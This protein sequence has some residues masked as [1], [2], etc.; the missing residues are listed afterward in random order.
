MDCQTIEIDK[1]IQK[2]IED[3]KYEWVIEKLLEIINP[4]I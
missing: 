1:N 4:K 3:K 2:L